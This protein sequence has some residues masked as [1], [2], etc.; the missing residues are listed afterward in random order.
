MRCHYEVLGVKRD[1]SDEDLKRAYRKLAL[2][3]HPGI[4]PAGA[5][6]RVFFHAARGLLRPAFPRA[7]F[8]K[9]FTQVGGIKPWAP[10]RGWAGR[11]L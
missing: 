9:C 2:R 1:A 7:I 4:P 6:K 3:W 10:A 8:S 5:R 11:V